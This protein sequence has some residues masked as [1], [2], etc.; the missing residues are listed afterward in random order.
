MGMWATEFHM[1]VPLLRDMSAV[2]AGC[3]TLLTCRKLPGTMPTA[4]AQAAQAVAQQAQAQAQQAAAQKAQEAQA[5]E[6]KG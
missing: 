3:K 2:M 5:K 1:E 4:D 6:A